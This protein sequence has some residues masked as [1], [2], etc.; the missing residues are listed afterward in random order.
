MT[1]FKR[2][3]FNIQLFLIST[4]VGLAVGVV[5]V[6]YRF[7]LEKSVLLR[8][9]IYKPDNSLFFHLLVIAGM[10]GIAML[11][12]YA[13]KRY[14]NISGSGI[15]QVEGFLCGR[16]K[17]L[18]GFKQMILKLLGSAAGIG[19]G[20]SLGREGPSVQ[21]GAFIAGSVSKL[22][23]VN[24]S[25]ERFLITGGAAAG[26]AAIFNAPLSSTIFA[27]ESIAKYQSPKIILTVLLAAIP[28]AW[29]AT[30]IFTDNPYA[31]IDTFW[32]DQNSFYILL[33]I[34]IGLA[35]FMAAS[36][37]LFNTLLLYFQK[38]YGRGDTPS[39]LKVLAI[40]LLTY[41]IGMIMPDILAGGDTLIFKYA[42]EGGTIWRIAV[43]FIVKIFI[44]AFFYAFGFPGGVFIPPLSLGA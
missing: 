19:M 14:P 16:Y 7:L 27:S 26:L 9:Y 1:I 2:H 32:P 35:L 18:Q 4:L 10:W 17:L 34:L 28:S 36:G 30:A 23:K 12:Y 31:F 15:P 44:P 25:D 40:V 20:F 41:L 8:D 3:R 6:P 37:K 43:I 5:T 38:H 21:S 39:W 29:L 42:K 22:F 33:P 11:I 13:V 24:P